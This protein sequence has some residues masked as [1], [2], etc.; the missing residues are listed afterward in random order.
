MVPFTRKMTLFVAK[1]TVDCTL[2]DANIPCRGRP[3]KAGP[4][5]VGAGYTSTTTI[6]CFI[7][8][9]PKK[10][11]LVGQPA[12]NYNVRFNEVDCRSATYLSIL[13]VLMQDLSTADVCSVCNGSSLEQLCF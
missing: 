13:H 10:T 8:L 5:T 3:D 9:T 1:T 11:H 6:T 12:Q 2:G 4:S 7:V